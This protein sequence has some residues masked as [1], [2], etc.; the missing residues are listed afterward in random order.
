[1]TVPRRSRPALLSALL[2]LAALACGVGL[3]RADLRAPEAMVYE[4]ICRQLIANSTEGRQALISSAWWPPLPV[5]VRLPLVGLLPAGRVPIASIAIS[6]LAAAL[7][8]LLM[9]VLGRDW[10]LGRARALLVAGLLLN[11]GFLHHAVDGSSATT[12]LVFVLLAAHT[13]TRWLASDSLRYMVTFGLCAALLLVTDFTMAP[14]LLVGVALVVL[15]R[16]GRGDNAG[17]RRAA[18]L[19]ALLPAVYTLGLWVLMN[20]LIMGDGLYF[21]R[22]MFHAAAYD[23]HTAPTGLITP[24][25]I[26]CAAFALIVL[27]V[28]FFR[29]DAPGACLAALAA[30]PLLLAFG[31]E[32][33]GLLWTRAPLLFVLHP[34][35]LVA[36]GTAWGDARIRRSRMP[37]SAWLL[38]VALVAG[39]AAQGLLA[40]PPSPARH[41]DDRAT[42]GEIECAVAT[43]SPYA[44]VFVCGYEGYRLLGYDGG[45]LFKFA[46][47]FNFNKVRNDYRGH[48]LYLLVRAPTGRSAMDSIHWQYDNIYALG[49]RS[50]LYAGDW[51]DWRLFEIIQAPVERRPAATPENPTP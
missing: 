23:L 40:P 25:D 21:L 29:H 45:P 9:A 34:L 39:P 4:S 19:L 46:L 35:A 24:V 5:L 13:L 51:D 28:A 44:L 1:M 32:R 43:E 22:S 50:T 41:D 14:W 49:S 2:A 12:T 30:A 3:W 11:P 15:L 6:A 37:L 42:Y 33:V 48:D 47:D 27:L 8:V 17:E 38:G 31:L 16:R 36:F 26:A 18:L 10:H 20:W 7:C